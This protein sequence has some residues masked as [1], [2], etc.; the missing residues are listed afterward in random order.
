MESI[1]TKNAILKFAECISSQDVEGISM[2]ITDDTVFVDSDGTITMGKVVMEEGWRGYFS[3]FPDYRITIEDIMIDGDTGLM[4][5][6][7]SGTYNAGGKLLDE[8]HWVIPAAW[9]AAVKNEKIQVWQLY[10][11]INAVID[12]IKRAD[13]ED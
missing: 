7:A 10:A 3:M 4:T 1:I 5:G 2:L 13:G 11:N 8:N 9:K 6:R 12:I